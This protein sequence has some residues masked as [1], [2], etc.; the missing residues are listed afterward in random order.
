MVPVSVGA[1]Y[2]FNTLR[3]VRPYVQLMGTSFFYME[4][5]NDDQPSKKSYSLGYTGSV[6][7]NI[8]LDWMD[9][10]SRWDIYQESGIK[11]YYL[12]LD[13][14]RQDTIL[15][16]PVDIASTA[17]SLGFTYEF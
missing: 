1:N 7:I 2:R 4:R 15:A 11:K 9:Q 12:T 5:R 10:E 13:F 14:T 16:R 3:V 17:L 6:G 8:P